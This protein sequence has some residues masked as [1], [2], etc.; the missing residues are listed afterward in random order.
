MSS[1]VVKVL[2]AVVA[3]VAVGAV[4]LG[5]TSPDG[6]VR[7]SPSGA[8]GAST[9]PTTPEPTPSDSPP[10]DSTS[11]PSVDPSA[12][13][14]ASVAG[15]WPGRPAATTEAG[16]IVDWCPAVTAEV[17]PAARAAVGEE[18]ARAAACR[19]VSFVFDVRYSRLSLPRPAYAPTDFDVAA[20]ALTDQARTRTF[21]TRVAAVVAAPQSRAARQGTGLVLLGAAGAGRQFFGT[22][23]TDDGYVDRAVWVDPEWSTVRID[24]VSSGPRVLLRASFDAA[25]AVPVWNPAAGEAERMRV[26]STVQLTLAGPDWRVDGWTLSEGPRTVAP[27]DDP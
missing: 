6:M 13:A 14:P 16:G 11:P 10:P 23:G 21:P 17:S 3:L 12:L 18:A 26:P 2:T 1:W 24:V 5:L 8:A 9:S 27:L 7:D 22:P 19:A 20:A 4:A 15:T 25:A